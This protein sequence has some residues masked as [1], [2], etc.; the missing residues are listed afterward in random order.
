MGVVGDGGW[1]ADG[2]LVPCVCVGLRA[3]GGFWYSGH[4]SGGAGGGRSAAVVVWRQ[5]G[6]S[7][8]SGSDSAGCVWVVWPDAGVHV[9]VFFVWAVWG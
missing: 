8:L 1:A 2:L 7:L 3:S 4:R 6:W 5:C 9:G